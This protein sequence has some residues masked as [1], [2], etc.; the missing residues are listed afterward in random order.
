M[1]AIIEFARLI[2]D[3]ILIAQDR[4]SGE[5]AGFVS[6]MASDEERLRDAFFTDVTLHD[7]AAQT[8]FGL[9]LDVLPQFRDQGLA[10]ELVRL[11]GIWCQVKGRRRLVITAHEE[12]VKMY[13]RMGFK[14]LG[15]SDSKWGGTVWHEMDR[16]L[17]G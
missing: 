12:L 17:D 13:E 16:R 10:R 2:P 9:S 3:Q 5:I 14:D 1:D 15:I 8:A 4:E 11:C 7:K 6:S